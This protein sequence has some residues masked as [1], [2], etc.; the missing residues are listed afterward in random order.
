MEQTLLRAIRISLGFILIVPLIVT[1]EPF[2]ATAFPFVV[3]KTLLAR[4][5]IEVALG[6][7]ILHGLRA[8]F[9][10]P[11]SW[12]LAILA[13]HVVVSL[14]ASILGVSPSRSLW[15]TYE[16]MYGWVDLAHWTVFAFLTASVFRSWTDWRGLLNVN[17]AVSVVVSLMALLQYFGVYVFKFMS[18]AEF[19]DATVGNPRWLGNYVA[20]NVLIALGFLT[21]SLF[22]PKVESLMSTHRWWTEMATWWKGF[23]VVAIVLD[24]VVFYLSG[25]RGAM[26]GLI[27]ALAAFAAAYAIWVRVGWV[28]IFAITVGVLVVSL[29]V[30]VGISLVPQDVTGVADGTGGAEND[31]LANRLS[32]TGPGV[33]S[34]QS[35][36]DSA[37]VAL[38]AFV[39][40]PVLGWGPEN[41]SVAFDRHGTAEVTK[42]PFEFLDKAHNQP[43]EEL[44]T[45][46]ILGFL[47]YMAVWVFMG[48]IIL[49]RVSA[50]NTPQKVFVLFMA[51]ALAAH[52]VESFFLF[53]M[54]TT[55]PQLYLLVALLVFIDISPSPAAIQSSSSSSESP[56]RGLL[57]SGPEFVV[58]VVAVAL[59][60][61][62]VIFVVNIRAF[63]G[64]QSFLNMTRAGLAWSLAANQL[65]ATIDAFPQMANL[66][67]RVFLRLG[68]TNWDAMR[69]NNQ[70]A[71][72]ALAQTE[73]EQ[74]IE[75][76]PE[77]WRNI[78][79]V[80][81]IYYRAGLTLDP[82]YLQRSR[83]LADRAVELAPARV[84]AQ[85]GLIRQHVAEGD[86]AGARAILES[87]AE[88]YP[89]MSHLLDDWRAI[90]NDE[91]AVR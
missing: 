66:P 47:S 55:A 14:A 77:D 6:L 32:T 23:W 3:G 73:G 20:I 7:W 2:P 84:G 58:A 11:R 87:F 76:E 75:A 54:P 41:Y 18:S 30:A 46:G 67:R 78:D 83:E 53:D 39:A 35:R 17:I 40:R 60:T 13:I 4:T 61:M 48:L 15:S 59:V 72:V 70:R 63:Q 1:T 28:R 33:V 56:R 80:A 19:L 74:A 71:F 65:E 90:I 50:L 34:A 57:S 12:L 10:W 43:L 69:E 86:Y 25:T 16:R 44:T 9:S 91:T 37:V 64:A 45:K 82:V 68:F 38:R 88:T 89:E 62:T 31:V 49:R 81:G 79:A 21:H 52:F 22:Q 85:Y 8:G 51:S 42:H 5:L 26:L 36:V 27:V 24:F 29:V